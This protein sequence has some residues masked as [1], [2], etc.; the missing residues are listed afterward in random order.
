MK[1]GLMLALGLIAGSAMAGDMQPYAKE[2]SAAAKDCERVAKFDSSFNK[3]SCY[4]YNVSAAFY[5]A[6]GK[7]GSE[8]LTAAIKAAPQ[9][10]EQSFDAAVQSGFDVYE[11]VKVATYANPKAEATYAQ[12]A[13]AYGADA[14]R[15]TEATAAGRKSK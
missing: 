4:Q 5:D 13:I 12:R 2:F 9:F 6:K 3:D 11:A 1:Q 15:V 10:S 14:T 8:V 7:A